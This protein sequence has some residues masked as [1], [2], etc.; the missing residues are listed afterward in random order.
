[1]GWESVDPKRLKEEAHKLRRRIEAI[2]PV[3]LASVEEYQ[4]VKERHAFLCEQRDDL[5]EA[6]RQLDA[7]IARLDKEST[8]KLREVFAQLR[9]AFAA[10]LDRKSTRL[11]SSHVKIS[12]AVFC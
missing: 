12:Y 5:L 3:N 8:E 2:G 1:T 9:A 4:E 6:K 7:V 10:I 11:N